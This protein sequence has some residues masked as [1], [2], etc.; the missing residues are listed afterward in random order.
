VDD[1]EYLKGLCKKEKVQ[2][3]L[4]TNLKKGW[5]RCPLLDIHIQGTEDPDKF[6][7][8][9]GHLDSWTYGLGDNATGDAAL[10]ELARALYQNKHLLRRS[11]R[12]AIWPG[13]STGR[14]AGSTWFADYYGIELDENC[15]AQVNCDSPGCRWAT[16][17]NDMDWMEE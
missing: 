14:Y 16:S 12:I 8:L 7:L 4:E 3:S 10:V 6:V 9:H 13:H 11:V 15:I 17:Y 1:G 2:V 5:F